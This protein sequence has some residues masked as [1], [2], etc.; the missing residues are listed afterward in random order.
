MNLA[1]LQS[2]PPVFLERMQHLLG[3]EFPQF[4]ASYNQPATL[5]LRVNHLK[6]SNQDFVSRTP[7]RLTPVPWCSSGFTLPLEAQ[8]GKQPYHAAGLYYLQESSAMAVAE[9]LSPQPGEVV[10]D[11]SAAP[12]GKAT[13][14][15]AK[16]ANQ[17]L[18]VANEIHPKRVWALAENLERCGV[19]NALVTN[20][21]PSRLAAY[22]GACFD[23][24]LVDA[25]CSGEG[26][27]RKSET[28]MAEW[29][30][31]MAESCAIRQAALLN[32]AA[33]LVRPGGWMVYS[34]CTFA[35][36]ENEG[37]IGQFLA[38]HPE[39][40]ITPVPSL[41]GL[42]Q[43]HPEW[44]ETFSQFNLQYA[45]RIW[46]HLANA[47]G[48]FIALL[49]HADGETSSTHPRLQA[50][51]GAFTRQI[52]TEFTRLYQE[53]SQEHMQPPLVDERLW[54]EG[55]YL[56]QLPSFLPEFSS[57]R[58]IHP[59]WWLG[60]FKKGRF[61]PSHALAMG[62]QSPQAKQSLRLDPDDPWIISYL[63]G[64]S[65]AAP[66]ED[67]WVLVT[68]DGYALGWG[69]RVNNVLKNHYP[70]GIRVRF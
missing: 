13:H 26:M 43:G 42:S 16:M 14:L 49:R 70:R 1:S 6:T 29:K 34:T 39:F 56:Y 9:V 55:S 4:L 44:A 22:F 61:E 69:R 8:P 35:P 58:V 37:L 12:G 52:P 60:S 15:A 30:P 33:R 62:I 20:E 66:G 36:Q 54:L 7:W 48:H 68:V 51:R 46:P 23:R 63:H 67:G 3:A 47:E 21:T 40:K 10:L 45:A 25:P 24:V 19:R 5:G 64:E 28:A 38:G 2:V 27:F 18:L 32:E 53:F 65:L 41:P 11:I 57:L 31:D 17:G 59:G 50:R